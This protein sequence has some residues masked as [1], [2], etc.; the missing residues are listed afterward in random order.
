MALNKVMHT[1][2][3]NVWHER[4]LNN[5]ETIA[6]SKASWGARTPKLIGSNLLL[7]GTGS[8]AAVAQAGKF[9]IQPIGIVLKGTIGAVRILTISHTMDDTYHA[10]PGLTDWIKTAW[11]IVALVITLPFSAFA[12]CCSLVNGTPS[13]LNVRLQNYLGCTKKDPPSPPEKEIPKQPSPPKNEKQPAPSKPVQLSIQEQHKQLAEEKKLQEEQQ[14]QIA[15]QQRQQQQQL[16]NQLAEQQRLQAEQ[17]RIANLQ[18]QQLEQQ[19]LMNEQRDRQVRQQAELEAQRQQQ[20]QQQ[21]RLNQQQQAQNPPAEVTLAKWTVR[22]L[23]P[24]LATGYA[25]WNMGSWALGK[26]AT[27]ALP[28]IKTAAV[29]AANSTIVNEA[30]KEC[31]KMGSYY[32]IKQVGTQVVEQC[33]DNMCPPAG[34]FVRYV[35][36]TINGTST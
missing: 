23:I 17:L 8:A 13:L 1:L 32:L 9:L 2:N 35:N 26:V 11:R 34:P 22:N 3:P 31:L 28:V 4:A 24:S 20:Q 25:V 14:R 29:T 36:A 16:Q 15:E 21:D 30:A 5:L 10:L 18:Q 19:R 33:V 6:K 7:I 12:A 27:T